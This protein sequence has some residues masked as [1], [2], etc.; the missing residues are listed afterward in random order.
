MIVKGSADNMGN[1]LKVDK[2]ELILLTETIRD[3]KCV[4]ELHSPLIYR[5]G[6]VVADSLNKIVKWGDFRQWEKTGRIGEAE[7]FTINH[8]GRYGITTSALIRQDSRGSEFDS[9]KRMKAICKR[10]LDIGMFH[11]YTLVA[12]RKLNFY[13]LSEAGMKYYQ[14]LNK[15]SSF[16]LGKSKSLDYIKSPDFGNVGSI[17][18]RLALNQL[19]IN[20]KRVLPEFEKVI[21][22]KKIFNRFSTI[23]LTNKNL[24][25]FYCVRRDQR[26]D[27]LVKWTEE[28]SSKTNQFILLVEDNYHA[29]EISNKIHDKTSLDKILFVTDLMLIE[30][31]DDCSYLDL[32]R[33]SE[34]KHGIYF[35]PYKELGGFKFVQ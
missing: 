33:Y 31:L 7:D 3:Y 16:K 1:E 20:Y 8:T 15:T 29:I 30:Q 22:R 28:L 25:T 12:D 24:I 13:C 17:L 27:N 19:E 9:S 5:E 23:M 21:P 6:K 32:V 4:S 18:A 14:N 2:P 35:V 10:L 11:R 26:I 34:D